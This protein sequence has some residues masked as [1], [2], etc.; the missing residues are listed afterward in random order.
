MVR[1]VIPRIW[2]NSPGLKTNRLRDSEGWRE[3]EVEERE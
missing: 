2:A 1:Y 3:K